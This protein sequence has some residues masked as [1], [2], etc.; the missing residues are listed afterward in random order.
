VEG[1]AAREDGLEPSGQTFDH[2]AGIQALV[3]TRL[4]CPTF[5]RIVFALKGEVKSIV[6]SG[7]PRPGRL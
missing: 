4:I 6:G 3:I 7:V 1:R 2:I 5:D